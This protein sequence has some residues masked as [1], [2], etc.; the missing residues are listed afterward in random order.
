MLLSLSHPYRNFSSQTPSSS[1]SSSFLPFRRPPPP[2]VLSPLFRTTKPIRASISN[3]APQR[4][5]ETLAKSAIHRIAEKLRSLGFIEDSSPSDRPPTG[6]GSAGEIFI[7]TP[8]DLPNHRVGHTID[9]SW[10]TPA[11][12]VP[13]PG[14]AICRQR[15][16]WKEKMKMRPWSPE[17]APSVAELTL[18]PAELKRL[19]AEGIRLEKRLKVGRR[20][21]RGNREWNP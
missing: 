16:Y 13:E 15:D 4:A 6:P 8:K 14:S 3:R 12:P 20:D 5:N 1:S 21:H 17:N 11:H 19:R 10:S 18:P 7:P 9:S 2:P